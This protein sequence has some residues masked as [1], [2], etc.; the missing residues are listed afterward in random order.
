MDLFSSRY[1]HNYCTLHKVQ[2]NNSE[3]GHGVVEEESTDPKTEFEQSVATF[4]SDS[5]LSAY[6]ENKSWFPP[7]RI[8]KTYLPTTGTP[9]PVTMSCFRDQDVTVGG[10]SCC[11]NKSSIELLS[12]QVQH[13]LESRTSIPSPSLLDQDL[14]APSNSTLKLAE[15]I[16]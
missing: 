8:Q 10:S 14:C 13:R 2:Q 6:A 4:Q 16:C 5:V 9:T 11:L 15:T 1:T 12:E 7:G 3:R